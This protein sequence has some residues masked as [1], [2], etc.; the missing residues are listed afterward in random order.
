MFK[1]V[2]SIYR[3]GFFVITGYLLWF[4][5]TITALVVTY[6]SDG[7]LWAKSMPG[8]ESLGLFATVVLM[9]I[10]IHHLKDE[11]SLT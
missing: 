5:I 7:K 11:V 10:V 4:V 3:F 9:V 6:I 8:I 2:D 1:I